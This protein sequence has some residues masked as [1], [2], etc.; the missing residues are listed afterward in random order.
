MNTVLEE[1]TMSAELAESVREIR[2]AEDM[3]QWGIDPTE[4]ESLEDTLNLLDS[5]ERWNL[6]QYIMAGHFCLDY[7]ADI[8]GNAALDAARNAHR[9][10]RLEFVPG[11]NFEYV[12]G[13][14]A[15]QIA[16]R[17]EDELW[18]VLALDVDEILYI[19]G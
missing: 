14:L 16:D 13:T 6:I 9:A 4:C 5:H 11:R 19:L 8:T 1:R 15:V 2:D 7:G 12:R 10:G 18:R 3:E 17:R